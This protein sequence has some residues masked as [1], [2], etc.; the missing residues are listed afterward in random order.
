MVY[1]NECFEF[2]LSFRAIFSDLPSGV[3]PVFRVTESVF[4][5]VSSSNILIKTF[6]L[7]EFHLVVC[8]FL[9]TK[10]LWQKVC[11]FGLIYILRAE[12]K[13]EA[14]HERNLTQL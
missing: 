4:K 5:R 14:Q 7:Q 6:S 12:L 11:S 13:W 9:P 8:L 10:V 2:D 3:V 1:T